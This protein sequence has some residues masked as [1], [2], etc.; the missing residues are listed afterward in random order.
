MLKKN[1]A[2]CTSSFFD[3]LR[4]FF[5]I[6]QSLDTC[7]CR[8]CGERVLERDAQYCARKVDRSIVSST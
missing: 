7:R 3:I 4:L 8:D 5:F 2:E 1:G 6:I